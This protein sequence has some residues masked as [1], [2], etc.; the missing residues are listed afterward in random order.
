MELRTAAACRENRQAGRQNSICCERTRQGSIPSKRPTSSRL[1][2][3]LYLLLHKDYRRHGIYG[4]IRSGTRHN[5]VQRLQFRCERLASGPTACE[6]RMKKRPCTKH[7]GDFRAFG[8]STPMTLS[9][10]AQK[11]AS[12]LWRGSSCI[13]KNVEFNFTEFRFSIIWRGS[14]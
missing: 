13:L 4:E 11:Q 9:F 3:L 7:E 6:E 8:K 12:A 5:G 14:A 2:C 1:L 10:A